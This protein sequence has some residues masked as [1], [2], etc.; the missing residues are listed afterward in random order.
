MDKQKLA[1]LL[2]AGSKT[3][4]FEINTKKKLVGSI[5]SQMLQRAAECEHRQA[6]GH[7][8]ATYSAHK[9][10]SMTTKEND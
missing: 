2:K 9:K 1:D 4:T 3:V 10:R 7:A 8:M 6:M 5:N